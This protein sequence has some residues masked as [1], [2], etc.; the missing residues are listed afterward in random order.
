[1]FGAN[2]NL[3]ALMV[4]VVVHLL[5]GFLWYQRLFAQQVIP[6]S[7]KPLYESQLGNPRLAMPL[8]I[9]AAIVASYAVG[10]IVN[11]VKATTLGDG[12]LVGIAAGLGFVA[13]SFG[14]TYA[15]EGRPSK[16]YLIQVGYQ[17]IGLTLMG[18]IHGLIR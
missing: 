17:V 8:A 3:I 9:V 1:M 18:A 13:T 7:G 16:L 15:F 12:A 5:L 14:A 4:G 10:V 2:V 6:G 11:L